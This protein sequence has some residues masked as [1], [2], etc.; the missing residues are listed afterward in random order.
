MSHAGRPANTLPSLIHCLAQSIL[1]YPLWKMFSDIVLHPV[2]N[3]HDKVQIGEKRGHLEKLDSSLF[4]VFEGHCGGIARG[5]NLHKLMLQI[6]ME[7]W[8]AINNVHGVLYIGIL[9]DRSPILLPEDTGV[10][11]GSPEKYPRNPVSLALFTF[12]DAGW[13]DLLAG[14]SRYPCSWAFQR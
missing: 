12:N 3:Y 11:A 4:H 7:T 13:I 6:P 8:L 14:P 9:I 10:L 5:V 2:P 1:W